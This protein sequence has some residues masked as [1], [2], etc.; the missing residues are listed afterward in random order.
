VRL[1]CGGFIY[2]FNDRRLIIEIIMSADPPQHETLD[3]QLP[4]RGLR[5]DGTRFWVIHRRREFGPFDY[6]WSQD[7]GGLSLLYRG[8]KFGE[9]CSSEELFADL[10]GFHLPMSVVEVATLTLGCCL[11]GILCG[12]TSGQR[13]DL[14]E[15]HLIE[16]GYGDFLPLRSL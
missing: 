13:E 6:E 15:A 4:W 11:Y 1:P 10:K 3:L 8:D 2:H 14:L 5:I 7:L 16:H 9:I 12:L